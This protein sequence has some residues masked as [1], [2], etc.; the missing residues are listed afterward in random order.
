MKTTLRS[1][2]NSKG[3][4]I[5]KPLLAQ[6]GLQG[7]AELTIEGDALVLRARRKPARLGWAEA[8]KRLGKTGD[9]RLI[10]GEFSNQDDAKLA[11]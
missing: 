11:W 3:I 8:S 7:E 4:V 9:D 1:I 5:P 6:L 10:L 2:G